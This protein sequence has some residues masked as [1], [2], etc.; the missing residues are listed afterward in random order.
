[1]NKSRKIILEGKR[2]VLRTLTREDA[3]DVSVAAN[4]EEIGK[5]TPLPY[6][7]QLEN[8]IK[9]IDG[10]RNNIN[11]GREFF[12][13][14]EFDERIVGMA[15]L[16]K[17]DRIEKSGEVGCWVGRE[18]R[19]KGLAGEA[20]DVILNFGFREESLEKAWG[21]VTDKNYPSIKLL[22][23]RGFLQT[24]RFSQTRKIEGQFVDDLVYELT[25]E[26]YFEVT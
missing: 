1:M 23:K 15:G 8:A 14:I 19:G 10:T 4:D 18:Y 21:R 6:P 17:L 16:L 9:L 3:Q 13:G 5:F 25:R 20:L 11:R 12:L 22:E 2:I 26:K 24:A 7:F